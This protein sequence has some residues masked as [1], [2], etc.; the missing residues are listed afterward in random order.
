MADP[1]VIRISTLKYMPSPVEIAVNQS[2]VWENADNMG[3]TATRTSAPAF[4]TGM[5]A[6]GTRSAPVTFSSVTG[7]DGIEYFCR[8]HPFMKGRII[9]KP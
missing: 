6:P 8:P 2:V 5:I 3:H 7:V 4:D 9:V 1:I